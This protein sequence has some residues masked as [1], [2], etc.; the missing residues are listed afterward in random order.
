MTGIV[1]TKNLRKSYARGMVTHDPRAASFA[2]RKLFVDKG[3]LVN[4]PWEATA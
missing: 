3:D 1:A 4:S 2:T